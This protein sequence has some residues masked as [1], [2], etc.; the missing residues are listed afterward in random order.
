MHEFHERNNQVVLIFIIDKHNYDK[1][2]DVVNYI[3]KN[4]PWI[5]TLRIGLMRNEDDYWNDNSLGVISFEQY[6]DSIQNLIDTYNGRLSF[7]ILTKGVLIFNNNQQS[8]CSVD[9]F[10]NVYT[11][12]TYSDCVMGVSKNHKPVSENKIF[13]PTHTVCQLTNKPH[14]LIYK[15]QLMKKQNKEL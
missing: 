12:M 3:D 4:A 9:R 8:S 11:D 6:R 7:E 5:N 2:Q 15:V 13:L 14:C 1:L 10:R